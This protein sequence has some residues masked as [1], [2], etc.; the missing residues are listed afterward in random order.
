MKREDYYK[1][2][3]QDVTLHT[4][5]TRIGIYILPIAILLRNFTCVTSILSSLNSRNGP[6]CCIIT[7]LDENTF[8]CSH[9]HIAVILGSNIKKKKKNLCHVEMRLSTDDDDDDVR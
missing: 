7:V 9:S 4:A 2:T 6:F 5:Y 1:V 8:C 3:K